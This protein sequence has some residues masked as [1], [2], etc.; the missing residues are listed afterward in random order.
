MFLDR[1]FQYLLEKNR[2]YLVDPQLSR[3][4]QVSTYEYTP[5][6]YYVF[7]IDHRPPRECYSID[8][9]DTSLE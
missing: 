5:N 6:L 1:L 3:Q 4:I 7:G 9:Q 2:I 8:L